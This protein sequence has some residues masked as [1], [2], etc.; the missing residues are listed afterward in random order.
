MASPRGR[1]PHPL[2]TSSVPRPARQRPAGEE[3]ERGRASPPCRGT[4]AQV[5]A[6]EPSRAERR[7]GLGPAAAESHRDPRGAHR[8]PTPG[9]LPSPLGDTDGRE[10]LLRKTVKP[11]KGE[12]PRAAAEA[13]RGQGQRRHGTARGRRLPPRPGGTRCP[14]E[15]GRE[16][17]ATYRR[18]APPHSLAQARTHR[19]G[20]RQRGAELR[21][22]MPGVA[23]AASGGALRGRSRRSP[24]PP[25]S[26]PPAPL[27]RVRRRRPAAP[28]P[29]RMRRRPPLP[30]GG[31]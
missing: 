6:A 20:A 1:Q 18:G 25:P 5:D 7:G 31:S 21:R 19:D 8:P 29:P 4:S 13:E 17:A 3:A 9:S 30:R 15:G 27:H 28:T 26:A 12:K 23:G 2:T 22:P 11:W 10:L 14:G 16:A 24:P